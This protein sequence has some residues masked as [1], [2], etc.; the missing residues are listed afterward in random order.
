MTRQ[1]VIAW[2]GR[3]VRSLDPG[4]PRWILFPVIAL[5]LFMLWIQIQSLSVQILGEHNWRQA[6]TYSVAYNFVHE[7]ADFFHPRIDWTRGRSGIMGMEAPILP[8]IMALFMSVLGDDASTGRLVVW[9]LAMLGIA[10]GGLLLRRGQGRGLGMGFFLMLALSPMALF[11]LRQIQPDGVVGMLGLVAAL[12]FWRSSERECAGDYWI[13]MAVFSTAVLIKGPGIFMAPAMWLFSVCG[14]KGSLTSKVLRGIPFVIP[15]GLYL[16]WDQWARHLNTAYNEGEVYFAIDYSWDGIKS[17]LTDKG[18]LRNI[19]EFLLPCYVSNWCLAPAVL[20]GFAASFQREHVR[21]TWPFLAWLICCSFFVA[22][23]SSRLHSHWYY[24]DLLLAPVCYFGAVGLS[25]VFAIF[26]RP[27]DLDRPFEQSWVAIA[28]LIVF[29]LT[30]VVGGKLLVG[31]NV[32][33][34]S[35]PLKDHVWMGEVG[36]RLFVLA[37][38]LAIP[39]ASL[40]WRSVTA[41]GLPLLF[42]ASWVMIPRAIHDVREVFDWRTR[43]SEWSEYSDSLDKVRSFANFYSTRADLFVVDIPNPWGLYVPLR[44]G[45]S[46]DTGT[47]DRQGLNHYRN[48]GARFLLHIA[49]QALPKELRDMKPLKAFPRWSLYCIDTNGC[50]PA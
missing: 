22:A 9:A 4:S 6:D 45:W 30:N 12:F 7:S 11:E 29:S 10:S 26:T 40:R 8:Y 1:S 15:L 34:G 27:R 5:C 33:A 42:L 43:K 48:K 19:F 2:T 25:Q 32:V 21:M 38:L 28:L 20:L 44:K 16:A 35:G 49:D 36:T 14:G 47:I 18:G 50:P 3:L 41:I 13:G 46:D 24:A 31:P 37:M 39:L 17:A 23:F